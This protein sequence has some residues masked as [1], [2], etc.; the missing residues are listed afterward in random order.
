MK[1]LRVQ[2]LPGGASNHAVAIECPACGTAGTF[3]VVGNDLAL[4]GGVSVG[5]RRCPRKECATHV[6]VAF[7]GTALRTTFPPTAIAFDRKGVPDA[8]ASCMEEALVCRA[9]GCDRAAAMLLRRTLEEV[10]RDLG[11]KGKT[12][13]ARIGALRKVVV[14]PDELL[15]A[16][17]GL[18]ILDDDAGQIEAPTYGA[19]TAQQFDASVLLIKEILKAVYQYRE[20]LGR[21]K[22]LRKS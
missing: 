20:L 21:L 1:F 5:H 12:L 17:E 10:C 4:G 14:L 19:V 15:R 3:E 22:G 8:V 6:F 7:E 11:A 16:L 18:R 2:A 9:M 13:A